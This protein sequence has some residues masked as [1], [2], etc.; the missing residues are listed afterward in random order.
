[1]VADSNISQRVL[2]Q[3]SRPDLNGNCR[4]RKYLSIG[5]FDEIIVVLAVIA[6]I[7]IMTLMILVKMSAPQLVAL[8]A[9]VVS[10]I[11]AIASVR[12]SKRARENSVSPTLFVSQ[13]ENDTLGID[14][15]GEG[16][17]HEVDVWVTGEA[18]TEVEVWNQ[19]SAR[20]IESEAVVP[21]GEFVD[22]ADELQ[23]LE[24]GWESLVFKFEYKT[25]F[26]DESGPNFRVVEMETIADPDTN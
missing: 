14:N 3:R 12:E 1:M 26:G 25:N 21:T 17:A 24:E 4:V 19:E 8:G 18:T 20:R 2:K 10:A 15:L 22:V 6:I 16:P 13:N 7:G 5:S 9:A 11:F 23:E